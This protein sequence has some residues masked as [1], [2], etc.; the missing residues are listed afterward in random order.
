MNPVPVAIAAVVV[1]AVPPLRRRV[2]PVA[3]AAAGL[4]GGV[5]LSTVGSA[6][7]IAEAAAEGTVHIARAVVVGPDDDLPEA[8]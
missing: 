8:D 5:A 2:V 7:S 6:I 1:V 4:V 3:S